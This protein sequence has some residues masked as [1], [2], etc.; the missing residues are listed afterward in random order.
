MCAS[1]RS[2]GPP[3][4]AIRQHDGMDL[5]DW[6]FRNR[7]TGGYTIAQFPNPALWVAIVASVLAVVVAPR[8]LPGDILSAV[9]GLALAFWA[10]DE[11]ARGVNPFRR[12]LGAAVLALLVVRLVTS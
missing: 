10:I 1:G 11:V 2:Y 3:R 4:R 8:G 7:V 6:M 9:G 12:L 5:I